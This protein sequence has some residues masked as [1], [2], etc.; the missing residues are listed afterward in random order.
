VLSNIEGSLPVYRAIA[1][2]DTRRGVVASW[3]H[4]LLTQDPMVSAATTRAT[5]RAVQDGDHG[6]VAKRVP[7][8]RHRALVAELSLA[9]AAPHLPGLRF[10]DTGTASVVDKDARVLLSGSPARRGRTLTAKPMVAMAAGLQPGQA[11]Y[12][13]PLV[14][15]RVLTSYVPVPDYDFGVM[16]DLAQS[17]AYGD[18]TELA[19]LVLCGVLVAAVI[20]VAATLAVGRGLAST[21][22]RLQDRRKTA[23]RQAM[24][25]P[26]TGLANRRKFE[27]VLAEAVAR[28]DAGG[29]AVSVTMLDLDRFKALNDTRG[30]PAGDAALRAVA[31]ELAGHIRDSDLVAR[32]GGDE[33]AVLHAGAV[34]EVAVA[35]AARIADA[36]AALGIVS[37]PTHALLLTVSTGSAQWCTGMSAAEVL[38]AA[39]VALYRTKEQRRQRDRNRMVVRAT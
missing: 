36:V 23:E 19:V 4:P 11:A 34:H 14:G 8:S 37:D 17:E 2:V 6:V 9:D 13:A 24:T 27:A 28:A 16:V 30:H 12:Y 38:A 7:L 32:L 15:R 29:P 3:P 22:R 20:G 33:F 31:R 26:L 21:E 18:L 1:L 35:V 5:F 39:D 25:D 10:G